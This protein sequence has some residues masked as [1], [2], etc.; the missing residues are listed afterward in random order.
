[1]D[2]MLAKHV[3]SVG[4]HSAAL[5]EDLISILK[6]HCDDAEFQGFLKSIGS[7]IAEIGLEIFDKVYEQ[8][9]DLKTEVETKINKY[10]KF[11]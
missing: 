1:M 10:G 6:D 9:P 7:V 5:L 2:R 3:I 4:F 11:I 8:Y